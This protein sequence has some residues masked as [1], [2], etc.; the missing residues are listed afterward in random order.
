MVL[1]WFFPPTLVSIYYTFAMFC[2]K[3]FSKKDD[4]N[5]EKSPFLLEGVP[6]QMGEPC[7]FLY[8]RGI[9]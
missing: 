5:F 6:H 8:V 7:T 3:Y 9:Y 1:V 2:Q 4:V